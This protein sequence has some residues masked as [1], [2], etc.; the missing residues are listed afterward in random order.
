MYLCFDW[1][2]RAENPYSYAFSVWIAIAGKTDTGIFNSPCITGCVKIIFEKSLKV[3]VPVHYQKQEVVDELWE[4]YQSFH[5][6]EVVGNN[7]QEAENQMIVMSQP[8]MDLKPP[9]LYQHA[10][11]GMTGV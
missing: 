7:F 3:N 4:H 8:A 10:D 6:A 1:Y 9:N 2:V 5:S 11:Q